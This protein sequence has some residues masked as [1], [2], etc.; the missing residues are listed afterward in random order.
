MAVPTL[1]VVVRRDI[2]GGLATAQAIHAATSYA[3]DNPTKTTLWA[4]G[5]VIVLTCS[6]EILWELMGF[7][8]Y[9]APVSGFY[10]PDMAGALTAIAFDG[11]SLAQARKMFSLALME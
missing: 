1:C 3:K 2:S 11:A 4:D 10:E 7:V 9:T 6:S 8:D 5:R